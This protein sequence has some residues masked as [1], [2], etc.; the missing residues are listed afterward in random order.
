MTILPL[1]NQI[2]PKMSGSR[3]M[4]AARNIEQPV[5]CRR[6]RRRSLRCF[7]TMSSIGIGGLISTPLRVGILARAAPRRRARSPRRRDRELNGHHRCHPHL[8]RRGAPPGQALTCPSP[9]AP[10]APAGPCPRPSAPSP[11][12]ESRAIS[13]RAL[14]DDVGQV[15]RHAA[16]HRQQFVRIAAR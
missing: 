8:H 2:A 15:G 14:A 12:A 16:R 10:A 6:T 4:P 11:P 1:S 13:P 5:Q 9:S 7:S 3:P